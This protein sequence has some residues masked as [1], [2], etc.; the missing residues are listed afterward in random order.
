MS[1]EPIPK[2]PAAGVVQHYRDRYTAIAGQL[3]QGEQS[4]AACLVDVGHEALMLVRWASSGRSSAP[5]WRGLAA[6][7]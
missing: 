2:L 1:E 3:H 5:N 6:R 4:K 7:R